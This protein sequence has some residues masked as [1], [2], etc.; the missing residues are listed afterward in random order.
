[1]RVNGIGIMAAGIFCM[2]VGDRGLCGN[3][4]AHRASDDLG[5]SVPAI[6]AGQV[7]EQNPPLPGSYDRRD[8]P[9]VPLRERGDDGGLIRS[10]VRTA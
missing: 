10:E 3:E 8:Q 6:L 4:A 5:R 1:M 9:W 7:F 2:E